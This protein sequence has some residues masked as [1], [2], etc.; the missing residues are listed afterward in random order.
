MYANNGGAVLAVAGNDYVV[1]AADTRLSKGLAVLSSAC[2]RLWELCPGVWLGVGGC[3]ADTRALAEAM[4]DMCDEYRF[5]HGRAPSVESVAQALSSTLYT[6]RQ[7]PYY[8]FCI[9]G[10]LDQFALSGALFTYDAVG[11]VERVRSACTGSCQ[12]IVVPILDELLSAHT[13]LTAEGRNR[14][15]CVRNGNACDDRESFFFQHWSS[16]GLRATAARPTCTSWLAPQRA[17]QGIKGAAASAGERNILLGGELEI[18]TVIPKA[19]EEKA[20][21]GASHEGFITKWTMRYMRCSA[22]EQNN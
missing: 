11:N 20:S 5:E 7:M 12:S 2:S 19:I 18:L 13:T 15:A 1:V 16:G 17:V 21:R 4:Q 3:L 9:L 14:H 22:M 6:R 8:T 10:G